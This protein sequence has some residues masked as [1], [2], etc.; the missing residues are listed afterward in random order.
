V[1]G[2]AGRGDA[3][4]GSDL[5]LWLVTDRPLPPRSLL[6]EDVPVTC[7][8]ESEALLT[9]LSYLATVEMEHVHI[10]DDPE[11]FLADCRAFAREKEHVLLRVA[12]DE[13]FAQARATRA[14][15]A[16]ASSP[17]ARVLAWRAHADATLLLAMLTQGARRAPRL[18]EIAA[19][20]GDEARRLA[21]EAHDADSR[22]DEDLEE[23][24]G[25]AEVAARS[26][27]R[28]L[29]L[30]GLDEDAF[31]A[32]RAG[33]QRKIDAGELGDAVLAARR[34]LGRY[35]VAPAAQRGPDGWAWAYS[36]APVEV[37]STVRYWFGE[38]DETLA[39]KTADAA[40]ALGRALPSP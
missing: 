3:S 10:V 25:Q 27:Q 2:S 28:A 11:G 4:A 30:S 18:R 32:A 12:T 19:R 7:F 1:T 8:S 37:T 6:F 23:P 26:T 16:E 20:F 35:I 22:V 14:R 39:L 21:G 29:E 36:Q 34:H 17:M 40:L 24:W 33:V 13:A 38:L 5:D 31:A 15:A 9:D